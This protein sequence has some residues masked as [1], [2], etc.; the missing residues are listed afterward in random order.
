[1]AVEDNIETIF[2]ECI[3]QFLDVKL[4]DGIFDLPISIYI[5]HPLRFTVAHRHHGSQLRSAWTTA[6]PSSIEERDSS[7]D[8]MS[9]EACIVNWAKSDFPE[10]LYPAIKQDLVDN[11]NIPKEWYDPSQRS[12]EVQGNAEADKPASTRWGFTKGKKP[13]IGNFS[14]GWD[15]NYTRDEEEMD[16]DV[17]IEDEYEDEDED[18]DE[19][20]SE[21][22]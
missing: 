1:M 4:T 7:K 11:L 3:W 18:E 9:I 20:S 2:L 13:L 5:R 17:E 15:D 6:H 19:E 8:N 16:E 10:E 22:F 21:P 12:Q 14:N